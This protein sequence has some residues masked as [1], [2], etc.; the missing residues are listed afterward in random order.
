LQNGFFGEPLE[1]TIPF[2]AKPY[3]TVFETWEESHRG[4]SKLTY[5]E[6]MLLMIGINVADQRELKASMNANSRR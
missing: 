4:G 2:F 5:V 1:W 6:G 3:M